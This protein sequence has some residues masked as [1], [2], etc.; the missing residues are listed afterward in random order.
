MSAQDT[1]HPK[2]KEQVMNPSWDCPTADDI[3]SDQKALPPS[4][5]GALSLEPSKIQLSLYFL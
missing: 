5:H 2:I 4:L 1:S 3:A